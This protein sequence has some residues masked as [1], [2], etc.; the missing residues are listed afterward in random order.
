MNKV[1]IIVD[2]TVDLTPEMYKNLN[3]R[4]E[5]LSVNFGEESFK[6][7]IDINPDEIYARVKKSGVLPSTAAISPETLKSLFEEYINKGMDIVF[8]GIG[9]KMSTTFQNVHIASMDLPSGRVFAVDSAN[10]STGTGLLVLKAV[11]LRDEGKSAKDIAD[12]LNSIVDKV[13]AKFVLD[14]LDYM[15]KGGRCSG[16]VALFGHLFHIHPVLK[17]VDGKIVVEKK[18]RGPMKA[19]YN[20]MIEEL[21]SDLP[22]VDMDNIMITHSGIPE[23]DIKYLFDEVS[24]LV[25][26]SLI[27][28]TRAGCVITSH[29]GP[30]TVGILYIKK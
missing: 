25:D 10:L 13:S 15:H 29:C 24:K 27:R 12:Y 18:V 1:Q 21:K 6:D 30:G 19:A 2:S 4:V 23:E 26:K 5:P 28:I 8:L 7:G 11:K 16:T 14:K 20:A 22:N 17:L 9:S 3:L